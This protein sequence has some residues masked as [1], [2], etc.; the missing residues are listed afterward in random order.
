MGIVLLGRQRGTNE[1]SERTRVSSE[2]RTDA[3]TV[4]FPLAIGNLDD[5]DAAN[6]GKL[7]RR[8]G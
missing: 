6:P 5:P 1:F 8:T 3:I 2:G 7:S 4:I